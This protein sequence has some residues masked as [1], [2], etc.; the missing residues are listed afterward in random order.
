M[1]PNILPVKSM[2]KKGIANMVKLRKKPS[3]L[4]RMHTV[5]SRAIATLICTEILA[6]M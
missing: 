5:R 6:V 3:I 1:A 2:T 4:R